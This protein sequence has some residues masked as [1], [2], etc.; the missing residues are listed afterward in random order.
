MENK[1]K[2]SIT[3]N[4]NELFYELL[5]QQLNSIRSN[6][7]MG[8]LQNNVEYYK[9]AH[10]E[11]VEI[12]KNINYTLIKELGQE[13]YDELMEYNEIC[14]RALYEYDVTG[15]RNDMPRFAKAKRL[16][17]T[18]R[19]VEDSIDFLHR[20]IMRSMDELGMMFKKEHKDT[21]LPVY[22]T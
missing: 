14:K 15:Y 22:K 17:A 21:R 3:F 7:I 19:S 6:M 1:S 16:T 12:L 9:V 13:R 20:E 10:R 11:V 4:F 2:E 8:N 5:I 18:K